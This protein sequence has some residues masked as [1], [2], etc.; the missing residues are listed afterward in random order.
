MEIGFDYDGTVTFRNEWPEVGAIDRGMIGGLLA[1]QRAGHTL[2]LWTC[3]EG[4]LLDAALEAMAA[5]GLVPDYANENPP[6][7]IA[8]FGGVDCR[9]PSVRFLVDDT[10][11]C[12]H[13]GAAIARLWQIA[14]GN[15]Q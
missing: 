2:I 13:R 4:A 1:C 6:D 3:R 15:W 7:R 5:Y 10:S 11:I 14:E 9:K 12:W 8:R